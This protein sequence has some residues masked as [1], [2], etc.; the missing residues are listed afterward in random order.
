MNS[1]RRK[2]IILGMIVM[3]AAVG[4]VFGGIFGYKAL[5]AY[6]MKKAMAGKTMPPVA[7]TTIRAAFETWQPGL[8][9]VG[10]LRAVRGVDVTCE[11]AGLVRS[12]H[13]QPGQRVRQGELLVELNTDA[14]IAQ[15]R[16]L[17][18]AASLA[19][20]V[21]ERDGTQYAARAISKAVLDADEADLKAKRA[22][23]AQQEA[24]IAKKIIR[25]PFDGQ[26]GI[27]NINPGQY[28][29]PGNKIVTLQAL[30]VLYGDFYLP[31]QELGRIRKGRTVIVSSDTHPG[32]SFSGKISTIDPK[33]DP[34]TRNVAVESII[35][36]SDNALLPGMFVN[37]EVQTG[38]SVR[39][40]TLPQTAVSFN[41][42]GEM[43]F[44]VENKGKDE[45]GRDILTARQSLVTVGPTRGDQVAVIKGVREGDIVI[46]S[47][48]FKLKPGNP[49][50]INNKLQPKNDPAPV[51]VDE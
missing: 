51:P 16:S 50:I 26:L 3:L 36:N 1:G 15:L 17:E 9:A 11:A 40:L 29:E 23:V 14:D 37:V 33:I 30:D 41:P 6:M 32:R 38:A 4:I 5:Q 19:A 2:K 44:L 45:S 35:H 18:A 49:I 47:G 21:Y 25:A 39:Y 48:H 31:Q 7:V 43:V 13:F 12:I 8:K 27:S 24:L 20:I 42:Y 22:Q 10:S 46:T 28:L 34:D